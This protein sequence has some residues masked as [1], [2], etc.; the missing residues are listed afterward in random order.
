MPRTLV[1]KAIG[2]CA[3]SKYKKDFDGLEIEVHREAFD[4]WN[5]VELTIPDDVSLPEPGVSFSVYSLGI[6]YDIQDISSGSDIQKN[7]ITDFDNEEIDEIIDEHEEYDYWDEEW[8]LIGKDYII[9]D[10]QI[11][12]GG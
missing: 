5:E 11:V 2:P 1:I 7:V 6:E 10:Y 9:T 8:E 12:S 3:I 4:D